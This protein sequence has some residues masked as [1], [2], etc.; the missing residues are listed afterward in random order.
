MATELYHGSSLR[1]RHNGPDSV[2]NHQPRDSLLNRLFRR[3]SKKTS[4]LCVTGL[5]AVHSPGT[6]EF[7][8]QMSSNAENV[9]IW[10]PHHVLI[11]D[12]VITSY[13]KLWYMY[14]I[15]HTDSF[16]IP[17]ISNLAK[18]RMLVTTAR[19][20]YNMVYFRENLQNEDLI[21]SYRVTFVCSKSN[22]DSDAFITLLCVTSYILSRYIIN[23]L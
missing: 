3:R 13:G 2:S 6:G 11:Y 17:P 9:S 1:W 22:L 4:K 16:P 23:W 18:S 12:W 7:P 14:W 5:C 10:W 19:C 21:A 8:A 20:R 15:I